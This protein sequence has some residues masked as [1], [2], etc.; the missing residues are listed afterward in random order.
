[1]RGF[2]VLL[3]MGL[4]ATPCAHAQGVAVPS[5]ER[6]EAAV[7][8]GAEQDAVEGDEQAPDFR[9]TLAYPFPPLSHT[10]RAMQHMAYAFKLRDYCADDR[11]PDAFV[12]V[13]LARFS[14]ITGREETC[15]TLADY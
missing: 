7:A 2:V 12:R 14:L 6:L 5:D 13:Q 10:V 9:N 3:L 4:I 11:V 15:R 8:D 1:M